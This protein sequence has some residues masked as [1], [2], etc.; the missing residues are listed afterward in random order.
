MTQAFQSKYFKQRYI[1]R[2]KRG[3]KDIYLTTSW[4]SNLEIFQQL[5]YLNEIRLI[6]VPINYC[7]TPGLQPHSE[8]LP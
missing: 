2:V 8:S 5:Q 4:L 6:S 3:Q 7:K 1:T